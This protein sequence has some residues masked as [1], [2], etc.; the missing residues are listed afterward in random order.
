MTETPPQVTGTSD[1][2]ELVAQVLDLV[3]LGGAV[4]LRADFRAPWAY[5]APPGSEMAAGLFP[6]EAGSMVLFHVV[7]EGRCWLA[8]DDDGVKHHLERGDVVVMPYGDP[9]CVG[10]PEDAQPVPVTT[11]LPP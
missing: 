3:R 5:S 4:F 9:H 11:L 10:N 7:G 1:H 6:G 8:L 2:F